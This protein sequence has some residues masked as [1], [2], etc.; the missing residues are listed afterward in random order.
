MANAVRKNGLT[1]ESNLGPAACPK[2]R[3][4]LEQSSDKLPLNS[5]RREALWIQRSP[6]IEKKENEI[7]CRIDKND[8]KDSPA[9][10]GE[11]LHASSI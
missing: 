11:S 3:N 2:A 8:P 10:V 1:K 7:A 6:A 9:L 4:F 5:E